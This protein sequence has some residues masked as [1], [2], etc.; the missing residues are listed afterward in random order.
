MITYFPFLN[1]IFILVTVIV[2]YFVIVL[3]IVNWITLAVSPC[4]SL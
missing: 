1:Y 3:V 4:K 2:F